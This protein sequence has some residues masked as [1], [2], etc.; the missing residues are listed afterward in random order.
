[1]EDPLCSSDPSPPY[2]MLEDIV[3]DYVE[4]I[5]KDYNTSGRKVLLCATPPCSA[6]HVRS[7]SGA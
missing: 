1:V 3:K 4:A 5:G 7:G 2:S 6:A